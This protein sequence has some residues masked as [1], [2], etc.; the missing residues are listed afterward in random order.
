MLLTTKTDICSP[1]SVFLPSHTLS[2]SCRSVVSDNLQEITL[3]QTSNDPRSTQTGKSIRSFFPFYLG[4]ARKMG[5]RFYFLD[6]LEFLIVLV[7]QAI[8]W[9]VTLF[10]KRVQS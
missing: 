7:A 9:A 1:S 8:H 10:N 5:H 2:H 3:A 6:K 4:N